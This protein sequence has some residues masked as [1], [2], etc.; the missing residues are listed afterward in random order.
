LICVCETQNPASNFA[1]RYFSERSGGSLNSERIGA[2][3]AMPAGQS[4][5]AAS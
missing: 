3:A 5:S 2:L 1:L 4:V